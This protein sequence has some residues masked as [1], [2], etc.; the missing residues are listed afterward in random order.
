MKLP[1]FLLDDWISQKNR[2]DS[3]IEYDL[4][5]STGPVWTLREL[6]ALGDGGELDSL[7][8]TRVSYTSA[9]GTPALRGAIAELE[10]VEPDEVQ[11][12]TGASEALLILL[13]SAAETG[14]NVVMPNPGF[15]A[16]DALARSLGISIRH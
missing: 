1:F 13:F 8:D 14:A 7:L 2:P 11:V 12:V 6:L 10:G 15:P 3:K 16:N 9:A 5:S 4:A